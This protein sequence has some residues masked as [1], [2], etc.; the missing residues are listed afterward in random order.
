MF[1][2]EQI[3]AWISA[4]CGILLVSVCTFGVGYIRQIGKKVNEITN[5]IAA[6]TERERA[7]RDKHEDIEKIQTDYERRLRL[8]ERR[9]LS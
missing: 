7:H 8:V 4:G 5:Y 3:S 9:T 1:T 6:A 2:L